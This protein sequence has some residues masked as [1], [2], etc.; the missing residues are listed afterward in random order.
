MRNC[1]KGYTTGTERRLTARLKAFVRSHE[2][3]RAVF[4]TLTTLETD[5]E[6]AKGLLQRWTKRML[7][8]CEACGIYVMEFSDSG[9]V[10]YHVL[11]ALRG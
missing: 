7:R 9:Q 8:Q 3:G 11:L 5:P 4:V 2:N 6:I 10:H 1:I